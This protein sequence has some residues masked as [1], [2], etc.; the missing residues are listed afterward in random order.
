MKLWYGFCA[1]DGP[2]KGCLLKH[3]LG[4]GA[5]LLRQHRLATCSNP[6]STPLKPHAHTLLYKSAAASVSIHETQLQKNP[7]KNFVFC[8]PGPG[9]A[10][11]PWQAM[12]CH[13]LLK[14]CKTCSD[15]L[16]MVVSLYVYCIFVYGRLQLF[17]PSRSGTLGFLAFALHRFG[18]AIASKLYPSLAL[19]MPACLHLDNLIQLAVFHQFAALGSLTGPNRKLSKLFPH[20]FRAPHPNLR[21]VQAN[22]GKTLFPRRVSSLIFVHVE[23]GKASRSPRRHA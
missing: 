11:M 18:E 14:H 3:L 6:L 12:L 4:I 22:K 20:F 5:A 19:R 15:E 10:Q 16:G 7:A 17:G 21:D 2:T 13:N 23:R 1:L 9:T 8:L